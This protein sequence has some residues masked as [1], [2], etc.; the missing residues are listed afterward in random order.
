MKLEL[1]SHPFSTSDCDILFARSF[2]RREKSFI[3]EQSELRTKLD[4][5]NAYYADHAKSQ[6]AA[7]EVNGRL[8]LEGIIKVY[9][10]YCQHRGTGSNYLLLGSVA[11]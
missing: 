7:R 6:L 8:I 1:S 3:R 5:Y 11:N 2:G 10:Y 9:Y 4:Q